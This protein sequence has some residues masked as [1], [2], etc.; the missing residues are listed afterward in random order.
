[1]NIPL[2]STK[3]HIPSPREQRVVR[4]RLTE[5]LNAG[6]D[7]KLTLVSASAG[8]GKTTLL[9]E[10]LAG[11]ERPAAWLSLDEG[12]NDPARFLTSLLAALRTIGVNAGEGLFG[13][14]QSP[15]PPP[16]E[17]V[18]AA[19]IAE[20]TVIPHPFILVLDDYHYIE[21]G[22]IDLALA[23]LLDHQP[24]QMHLVIATRE[25]PRL[26]I[27]RMRVR[28]QIAELRA[29]DMRFTLDEATEFLSGTMALT[30]APEQIARLEDRTEGWIAALQLAAL[31]LQG[32]S[33]AAG[34]IAQFTGSHR[35]VFDYLAEEVLQRQSA[36][37]QQFLLGTSILDRLCEPLCDA[38]LQRSLSVGGQVHLEA[39]ERANL[40]IV[41]LD[42]ERRWYRYHHL[43]ADVLRRRLDSSVAA[44]L[45]L[46]ASLWY[47]QHDLPF[48]AF[49]HAIASGEVDRAARL[50]E[51]EGGTP[52]H[53]R[54]VVVPILNW[55]SSLP[56]AEL[57]ARPS[58]RV[59]YASTLLMVGRMTDVEPQLLS[60][61]AAL[62]GVEPEEK[63][64]DLIGHM[65]SIRAAAA[66]SR[67]ETETILVQSRR[68]LAYLHPDNLPVRTA[69]AWT[70][71]YAYQLQGDRAAAGKAYTEALSISRKIGHA[72][73]AMMAGLG[74]GN[75]QE[76]DNLLYEAA[77]T[78]WRVLAWAGDP[79]PPAA[80]EVHLGLARIY[81]EWNDLDVAHHHARL[82]VQLAQQFDTADRAVAGEV[83]LARLALARGEASGAAA[84]LAQA[85]HAAR[86]QGFENQL[87]RIAAA[88]VLVLLRQGHLDAAAALA[89]KY[90]LQSGMARVHL[91][92][93]D[94]VAA[95]AA[96]ESMRE[97]AEKKGWADERLQAMVLQT[98]AL[99]AHGLKR[100]A[101]QS[102]ADAIR[103]AELGGF[104]R[105]FVDEG[106]AMHRVMRE[107]AV[108]PYMPDAIGKLMSA[109]EAEER[110]A[111]GQSVQRK[112]PPIQPLIEPLSARELEVLRL[113]AQGCSNR[114]IGERLFL[115]VSTVKGHNRSIFDK[116]QVK[117]RTEAV[118]LAREWELL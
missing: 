47:E 94:A 70:L 85:E 11:C 4:P 61:E 81:Y 68:A 88:N 16:I 95:L 84:M 64:R 109:L 28:G 50:A 26:P 32:H 89:R 69:T 48:E 78:Y 8:F 25:E 45:H 72:T 63:V 77:D 97:R 2:I 35:F 62:Q 9:G 21:A 65:A 91:A 1:M 27:A 102:L 29:A 75:I 82:A 37:I 14:L 44:D 53:F 3:L 17:S 31:S 7:R 105:I 23:F 117:R 15:Q 20:L 5:R 92:Q 38:V 101:A 108:Q 98:I 115:A 34:F 80:C 24:L 56:K 90:E 39:I 74:L 93:G 6:L 58:L 36:A 12:D 33:D 106:R 51:G 67:H 43:F 10:W 112:A 18:L 114:E 41:P 83:L 55:L 46:R 57:D 100:E 13:M 118:A 99:H 49:Q 52:L 22:A 59:I 103:L 86:R 60:A 113:I 40:F 76:A 111:E 66:V 73:I 116:M 107:S 87:P 19:L 79:P 71:G 110:W 30:L 104:V 42:D 54:G 96:L